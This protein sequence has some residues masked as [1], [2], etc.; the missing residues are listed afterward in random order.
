[1]EGE[2][3]TT[4]GPY[5]STN[6]LAFTAPS[7]SSPSTALGGPAKQLPVQPVSS[8]Q[9]SPPKSSISSQS[10]RT[11]QSI[12]TKLRNRVAAPQQVTEPTS[13][14][15]SKPQKLTRKAVQKAQALNMQPQSQPQLA[16]A[17]QASEAGSRPQRRKKSVDAL[18]ALRGAAMGHLAQEAVKPNIAAQVHKSSSL[19]KTPSETRR[20]QGFAAPAGSQGS[21]NDHL[22][23]DGVEHQRALAGSPESLKLGLAENG[24]ESTIAGASGKEAQS[25][26]LRTQ[27][28]AKP[29]LAEKSG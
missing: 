3:I 21:V 10:S 27:Q 5:Q 13:A 20:R 19:S 7:A 15:Q 12:A 28:S 17:S 9:I 2:K 4:P 14:V 23:S 22:D 18:Q 29:S 26:A 16:A 24:R 8:S 25:E 6:A 1:M 11:V